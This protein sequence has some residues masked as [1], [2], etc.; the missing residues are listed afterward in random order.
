MCS[1]NKGGDGER[2]I[3]IYTAKLLIIKT[4]SMQ[5]TSGSCNPKPSIIFIPYIQNNAGIQTQRV[6]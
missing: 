1:W 4:T 2:I 3:R 6:G 5:T